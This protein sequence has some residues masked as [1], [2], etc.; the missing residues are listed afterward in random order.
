[1]KEKDSLSAL[2]A[3][4]LRNLKIFICSEAAMLHMVQIVFAIVLVGLAIL[5]IPLLQWLFGR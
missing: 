2:I 4:E 5:L 3:L 1:M